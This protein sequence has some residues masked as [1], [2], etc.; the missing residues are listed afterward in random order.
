MTLSELLD[1]LIRG[2]KVIRSPQPPKR[3]LIEK[4]YDRI[5]EKYDRIRPI[6]SVD[7]D[8]LLAKLRSVAKSRSMM[9]LTLR[10]MRVAAS[11]LFD[12][13]QPLSVDDGFL[14]QYLDALRSIR[15]RMAIKR[16]I[17]TY[18]LHF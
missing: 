15:S 16:L 6:N 18:C 13:E 5:S 9:E 8:A 12:G 17:H 3:L 1:E 10:E 7:F 14:D 11:C 4:S 2:G